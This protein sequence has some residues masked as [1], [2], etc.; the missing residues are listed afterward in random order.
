MLEDAEA[1]RQQWVEV[2]EA[3]GAMSTSATAAGAQDPQAEQGYPQSKSHQAVRQAR[4]PRVW[5]RL[6]RL[7][8]FLLGLFRALGQW[9][10]QLGRQWSVSLSVSRQLTRP[11][12]SVCLLL[13]FQSTHLVLFPPTWPHFPSRDSSSC[14]PN[15][16]KAASGSPTLPSPTLHPSSSPRPL[17][18][19]HPPTPLLPL[20]S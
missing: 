14:S 3:A 16:Q 19:L 15:H 20:E 9:Y 18:S 12:P 10:Q 1:A 6:L 11:T 7:R 13:G 17:A 5:H 8:L 2:A 4:A